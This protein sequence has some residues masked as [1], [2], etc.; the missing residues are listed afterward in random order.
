MNTF[1][2]GLHHMTAK[3]C[4]VYQTEYAGPGLN[5]SDLQSDALPT[6]LSPLLCF[7]CTVLFIS[8]NFW[9]TYTV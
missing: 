9:A 8:I 1:L 4:A 6:E 3:L 2:G 5:P 7:V